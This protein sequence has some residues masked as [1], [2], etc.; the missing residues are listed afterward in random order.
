MLGEGDVPYRHIAIGASQLIQAPY[1]KRF[2][3]KFAM[4]IVRKVD[5]VV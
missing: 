5:V 4:Q 3:A 1:V 2:L